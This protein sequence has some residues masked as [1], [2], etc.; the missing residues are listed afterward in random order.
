MANI[1]G[2]IAMVELLRKQLEDTQVEAVRLET[3]CNTVVKTVTNMEKL[4]AEI[5]AAIRRLDEELDNVNKWNNFYDGNLHDAYRGLNMLKEDRDKKRRLFVVEQE[6]IRKQIT[7][8][9]RQYEQRKEAHDRN[10]ELVW[11]KIPAYS[12]KIEKEETIKML[13]EQVNQM[14]LKNTGSKTK[15]I[16]LKERLSISNDQNNQLKEVLNQKKLELDNLGKNIMNQ[17]EIKTTYNN[18]ALQLRSELEQQQAAEKAI[19]KANSESIQSSQIDCPRIDNDSGV[20]T[21]SESAPET[22][23]KVVDITE[24]EQTLEASMFEEMEA[25]KQPEILKTPSKKLNICAPGPMHST[26]HHFESKLSEFLRP[27]YSKHCSA[28]PSVTPINSSMLATN[29]STMIT[30]IN[31]LQ[32]LDTRSNEEKI[33]SIEELTPAK[34]DNIMLSLPKTPVSPSKRL[35]GVPVFTNEY[36]MDKGLLAPT[37]EKDNVLHLTPTKEK[38]SVV[39]QSPIKAASVEN[40]ETCA[41]I[42]P[43]SKK[44][45]PSNSFTKVQRP[46]SPASMMGDL[47][48]TGKIQN[49]RENEV[50]TPTASGDA[51]FTKPDS[52]GSLPSG[53][54]IEAE[55]KSVSERNSPFGFNFDG[56]S[57]LGFAASGSAFGGETGFGGG[58]GFGDGTPF[59]GSTDFSAGSGFGGTGSNND[60]GTVSGFGGTGSNDFGSGSGFGGSTFGGSTGFGASGDN[61]NF[62]SGFG[63]FNF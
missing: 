38:I 3:R 18:T 51:T 21:M 36:A 43:D 39:P 23:E 62:S 40:Q 6:L 27:Q 10:I 45:K 19:E 61:S 22:P 30:P 24:H 42:Q 25:P 14:G 11:K 15:E 26:P 55:N 31:T 12:L 33:Q 50:S 46:T 5:H 29:S 63:G 60:F 32:R 1:S 58:S 54:S 35:P 16:E 44:L 49:E 13:T 59:T 53:K 8:Q 20:A 28:P 47:S 56:N 17:I 7:G 52:A 9:Q 2:G 48:N 37:P 57:P 41:N 4:L 34:S